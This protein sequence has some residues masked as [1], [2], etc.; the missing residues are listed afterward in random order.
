MITVLE[1]L[2]LILAAVAVYLLAGIGFALLFAGIAGV[3]ACEWASARR[4]R[5]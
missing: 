3:L 5:A 1:V 2:F 4:V